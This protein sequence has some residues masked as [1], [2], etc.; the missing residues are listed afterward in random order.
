MTPKE[1]SCLVSI[2]KVSIYDSLNAYCVLLKYLN[3]YYLIIY[4]CLIKNTIKN[5]LITNR[6]YLTISVVLDW[7]MLCYACNC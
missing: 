7:L 2:Y 5:L 3:K 4:I 1:S 6:P